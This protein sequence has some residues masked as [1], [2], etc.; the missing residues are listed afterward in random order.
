MSD[1]KNEAREYR[2]KTHPDATFQQAH[3]YA[4]E[5]Y[6]DQE[7]MKAF[8][9]AWSEFEALAVE[10]RSTVDRCWPESKGY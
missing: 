3:K 7:Q 9:L 8:L 2:S 5:T 10:S 4:A 6:S 1:M